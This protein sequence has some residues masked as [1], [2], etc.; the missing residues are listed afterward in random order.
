[1]SAVKIAED[2]RRW[3]TPELQRR[4]VDSIGR[5]LSPMMKTAMTACEL[6]HCEG[7]NRYR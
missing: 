1:M 6:A 5:P 4:H 3:T 7:A 2:D